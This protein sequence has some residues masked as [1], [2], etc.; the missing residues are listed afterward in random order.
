MRQRHIV[1]IAPPW[2][3]VPPRGY[4]GIEVVVHLLVG[5]LRERGWRVSLIAAEGS[6]HNA[7][8]RAPAT[9]RQ[10][11][12]TRRERLRELTYA[13]RVSR[14]LAEL[15]AVDLIHDHAGY[16][17]LLVASVTAS[18]PLV[19]TVHGIAGAVEATFLAELGSSVGLIAI[20][21]HQ[22]STAATLPWIGMVHNA[23]DV[24]KLI[25]VG[26]DEKEPYLVCLARVHPDKGQHLAIAAAQR[27]G[28]RLVLAG[29]VDNSVAGHRYFEEEVRPHLD[30][31]RVVHITNTSGV[32]K[33]L[34][35]ARAHALL[36]P[37]QW[38][39]PFGL[40]MVEAMA[41][42]TPA[43]SMVRGAA[44]EIIEEGLTG[45]LV[46]DLD[47]MVA[48][49]AHVPD[50]DPQACA[51]LARARFGGE[52][53]VDGYIEVYERAIDGASL[54]ARGVRAAPVGAPGEP[55]NATDEPEPV[56]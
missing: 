36:A 3:P 35:L 42:G 46:E 41:S 37:T 16:A 25:V 5:G 32:E 17:S 14:R 55:V 40:A 2:Y 39:E 4:G 20:S 31:D 52:A 51:A 28:M 43:I 53:M 11:L 13:V 22:R 45:F 19:H 48:A 23:V 30:G 26:R 38:D 34:L 8:V 49:L 18:P 54:P 10:E 6:E 15:G 56:R 21:E 1:L 27:T 50:I 9:W 29:K 44:P 7:T 33:A 47:G 12:G 24:A